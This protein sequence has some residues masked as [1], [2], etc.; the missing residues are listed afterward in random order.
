MIQK[1]YIQEILEGGL[2]AKVKTSQGDILD[3]V[4]LLHSYGESSNP[5]IN[6]NSLVLLFYAMG[7]KSVAFG[8]P[9]NPLLQ[10]ILENGEK[11]IGNFSSGNKMTFKANGDVEIENVS[12][13]N[14]NATSLNLSGLA[15]IVGNIN[16]NG[17]YKVADTKVIGVQGSAVPDATGGVVIDIQARTALNAL[18]AELRTHGLIA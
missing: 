2:R 3:N 14:I 1:G 5:I 4:L 12:D 15:D 11:A 6:A 16:T 13:V 7:S 9:Y 8:I 10:P 17:V 18:L